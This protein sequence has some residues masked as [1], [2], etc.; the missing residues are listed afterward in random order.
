MAGRS[1]SGVPPVDPDVVA[2]SPLHVRPVAITAVALGG[3]LGAPARYG[4]GLVFPQ[5]V[6]Q[7]PVTTFAIN[8]LGAFLLGLLL[9]GLTRVGP[10]AGWRQ[11]VRLGVGTG[12]LGSFTTYSTLAVDTDELLR[13]QQWW[14]AGSYAAG[15][16]LAGLVATVLGIALGAQMPSRREDSDR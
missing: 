6:G 3:L 12:V 14:A 2:P 5:V 15:S 4:L 7:W 1:S 11:L 13:G 8:V 16:V 9:E 10:D